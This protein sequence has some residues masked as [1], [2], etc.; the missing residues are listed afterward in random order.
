MDPLGGFD[1]DK[2]GRISFIAV[3]EHVKELKV[4]LLDY[5][6]IKQYGYFLCYNRQ[7]HYD[8]EFVKSFVVVKMVL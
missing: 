6:S 2:K 3:A 7:I 1:R 5:F 4:S 8:I